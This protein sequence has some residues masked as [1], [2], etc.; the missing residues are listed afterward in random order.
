VK[1]AGEWYV[2]GNYTRTTQQVNHADAFQKP[3]TSLVLMRKG[4]EGWSLVDLRGSTTFKWSLRAV[5][6]YHCMR[7]PA[8]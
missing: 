3:G 4:D 2:N 1:G 6:L 7:I 5:E 8:G